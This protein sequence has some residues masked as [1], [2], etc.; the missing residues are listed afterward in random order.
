MIIAAPGPSSR[1]F[2][3]ASEVVGRLLSGLNGT[4]SRSLW[5]R[6][7]PDVLVQCRGFD[8]P[9]LVA[10]ESVDAG[11]TGYDVCV[12]W[13]LAHDESLALYALP[14]TRTSFVTYCTVVGRKVETIYTEYP[15][16]TAAWLRA[17]ARQNSARIVRMRGSTE[18]IIRVDDHG[19]GV[20]LVTSGQTLAANGL[21]MDV[22]LLATDMCLVTRASSVDRGVAAGMPVLPMPSF[23]GGGD[24]RADV[25]GEP[26]H[27]D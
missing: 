10:S 2:G 13:S 21:D 19:A 3:P 15:A 18:G 22:P 5:H 25:V 1:L 4:G 11:V 12:E 8:V 27:G 14:A 9:E 16:I 26:A 23:A 6:A 20:L 24:Q 7:G 17:H